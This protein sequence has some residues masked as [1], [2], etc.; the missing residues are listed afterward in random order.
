MNLLLM[1]WSHNICGNQLKRPKY[2]FISTKEEETLQ[3]AFDE[4]STI[5]K[6]I[7]FYIILRF[8]LRLSFV[9]TEGAVHCWSNC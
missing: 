5:V 2:I 7:S 4:S 6:L 1:S 8:L 9:C 3:F